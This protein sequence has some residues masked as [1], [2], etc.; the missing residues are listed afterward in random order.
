LIERAS[1]LFRERASPRIRSIW[2]AVD[3]RLNEAH[4]RIAFIVGAFPE[5][6]TTFILDQITGLLERGHDVHIFARQPWD[7][8]PVHGD[9]ERYGL[10]ARTHYWWAGLRAAGS[11]LR[12]SAKLLASSPLDNGKLFMRSLDPRRGSYG[13][14]GRYWCY[15]ATLRA[16]PPFDVVVAQFGPNGRIANTLR[17]L[18]AFDA[19]IATTFLGY[20][21]SRVLRETGPD[22]YRQLFAQGELMLPLTQ[23]FK[24][25]LLQLGCPEE[26]IA[27]HHVGT[28]LAF[29][30]PHPRRLAPGETPRI[31]TVC[32]LVE[33][34]GLDFGLRALAEVKQRGVAF[35]VDIVGEGP[36]LKNLTALRD[37]L[38][39]ADRVV[40][41]GR[42]TRERVKPFL[43]DGHIFLA[44]SVTA[45]NGDEEGVPAAIKE[46]LSMCMPV[47]S[48]LHSGIPELVRNDVN[49]YVVKEWDVPALADR[50]EQMLRQPE[51]WAE[52]G[53]NGRALIEAEYDIGKLNDQLS[54]RLTKLA[55]DYK[56]SA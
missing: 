44:P 23:E 50:I 14:T 17:N 19:P 4:M 7:G 26:K 38:D 12:D 30:E 25:R 52:L 24:R 16:L 53:K 39:L 56:R 34:K 15:A 8:A 40:F 9:F 3:L 20:D 54:A 46:A 28:Q 32:R 10:G 1:S 48:T 47:V 5:L 22:Y 55:H 51:R 33:K 21:L 43:R 29:F 49:G 31:V 41:H 2:R 6:S 11:V 35:R 45:K 42:M 36:E 13:P 18:G 37:Q 27:V